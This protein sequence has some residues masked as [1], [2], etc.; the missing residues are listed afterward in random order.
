MVL[1]W[2]EY[3]NADHILQ[4]TEYFLNPVT[5]VNNGMECQFRYSPKQTNKQPLIPEM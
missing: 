3:H 2:I 5:R 4:K 1:D